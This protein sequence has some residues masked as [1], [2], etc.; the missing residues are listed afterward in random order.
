MIEE[1]VGDEEIMVIRIE[2][3]FYWM[4]RGFKIQERK[5]SWWKCLRQEEQLISE[6]RFRDWP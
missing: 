3:P 4:E 1:L 6:H 5:D 2:N